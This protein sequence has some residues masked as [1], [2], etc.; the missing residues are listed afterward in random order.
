MSLEKTAN[1]IRSYV[2]EGQLFRASKLTK[3][4]PVSGPA[5]AA[6][7]SVG[8]LGALGIHQLRAANQQAAGRINSV[9]NAKTMQRHID[10]M[11]GGIGELMDFATKQTGGFFND[12]AADIRNAVMSA[13]G[14]L[15]AGMGQLPDT[16]AHRQA[17]G[18]AFSGI[19]NTAKQKVMSTIDSATDA[20]KLLI[21]SVIHS[22]GE[23]SFSDTDLADQFNRLMDTQ[24]SLFKHR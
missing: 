16:A 19:A 6:L 23:R 5:L 2:K 4:T 1:E 8:G 15:P 3:A 18:G 7:L 10:N 12:T 17:T 20:A 21:N 9:D 22:N 24:T 14:G 13:A 11:R